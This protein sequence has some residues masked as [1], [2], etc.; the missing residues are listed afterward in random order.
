MVDEASMRKGTLR[1]YKRRILRVLVHIQ[2]HLD[3][4]LKKM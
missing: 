3:E 2:G 4:V 1:D